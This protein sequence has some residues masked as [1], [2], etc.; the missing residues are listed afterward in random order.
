M[1]NTEAELISS[2]CG[3]GFQEGLIKEIIFERGLEG[4]VDVGRGYSRAFQGESELR[5][6]LEEGSLEGRGH[7]AIR[8]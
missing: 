6:K 5:L 4:E 7:W 3:K 8:W 2:D 1:L